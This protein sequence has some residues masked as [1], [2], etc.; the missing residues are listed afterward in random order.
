MNAIL[1][2]GGEG[3]RL[4]SIWRSGPKPMI[5]LLGKPVMERMLAL[6]AHNGVGHVRATLRYMPGSITEYFGDGSRFGLR[7]SYSVESQPL[8]T[9]GGVRACQDFY[10]KRDFLVVSGDAACD[11]DL[12]ALLECHRRHRAAVTMAL[13]THPAP[14]SYGLVV[15]DPLGFVRGFI[16]KPPWNRVVTDRVNTGIYAVSPRAMDYVPRGEPFDF[17]K[18][19]FPRLLAAG[20]TVIGL[21]MEGYWCDVG[22]PRAYYQCNLDA[23]DGKLHLYGEDAGPVPAAPERPRTEAPQKAGSA[24]AHR[25]V[26]P[27]ASRARLMRALTERLMT[28]AGADFADGLTL[29]G[30]HIAPE[31]DREAVTIDADAPETLKKYEYIAKSFNKNE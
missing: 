30:V 29:P 16:E 21:P 27:C 10:G 6:L 25:V 4:R 2:A 28:E 24:A 12:R 9:A 26:I 31:T 7:L 18:D 1:M 19:L 5:P 11:F 15:T 22:T 3:T 17:A 8:G 13:Y 23:L 20:E 14:T